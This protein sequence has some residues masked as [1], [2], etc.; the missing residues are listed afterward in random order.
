MSAGSESIQLEVSA[1]GVRGW[2]AG[3]ETLFVVSRWLH[4]HTN[5]YKQDVRVPHEY[6]RPATMY[7]SEM[8]GLA[9]PACICRN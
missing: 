4:S 6:V 7:E 8:L 1:S 5:G 9:T 3:G 2:F